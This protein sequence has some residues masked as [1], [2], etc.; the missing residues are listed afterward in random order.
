MPVLT[1]KW[2]D[3]GSLSVSYKGAGN[4]TVTIS[5]DVNEGIDRRMT[6][7]FKDVNKQVSVSR[8]VM[9]IGRREE[10]TPSDGT[11]TLSDNGTFNV[12]K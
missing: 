2:E 5:S 8:T 1:K 10:F 9:Q 3:G 6:I 12:I 11:F 4:D 7:V